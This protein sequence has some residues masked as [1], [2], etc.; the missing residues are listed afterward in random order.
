MVALG[1][2]NRDTAFAIGIALVLGMLFVPLPPA[3]LDL[4]LACSL[5][6]SVLILMVAL[7]IPKPL[8]FNSFPTLLLVVTMLRLSLNV[9]STRL[10]LSEG[11]TGTGAAGDVIEGFSRFI[12]GG[13]FV[14]GI[15]IFAIL[16]VI[17]FVVITKG[18]TRIAEVSA[19]FSLDAMPGKQ[20]AIDADLGSGLI[21]EA[22]AKARRK[23]LEDESGFFGAMDGASKFVRGDAVA[24]IIITLINVI[25]GIL[26]GVLQHGM[27]VGSAASNYTVLTIGDGLVTQIPA[28]VVSLAA[29]LIVTKGGTEGATNE[30]ILSQLGRFPKALFMAAGLLAFIGLLPGFPTAIFLLLSAGLVGLGV[31]LR[32][33]AAETADRE[34]RESAAAERSAT[35]EEE[36]SVQEKMRLDDLRLDLGSG[37]V[38]LISRSD[39]ALPGK[40][41]SLRNLFAQD[42]GFVLPAVRIK[43]E[44]SLP[45]NTYAIL[46][47]GVEAARGE[48]R[49][50]GMMVINPAGNDIDLAGE[51]TREP[52]FGLDAVWI[53]PG[54]VGEAE[55]RGYTVVDPESVATTHLTE[56]IKEHMPELL[57]Y[58]AVQQLVEGLERSYQK[59]VAEIS[60]P[61]PQILLQHVLQSLLTERV[62]IRNLP[63]IVEAVAE[64]T[65]STS[66]V[67]MVTEHVRQKLANQ[68]CRGLMD[69]KGFVPVITLSATWERE[70]SEAVRVNGDQRNFLMSPQRVQEFVLAARREI[71]TFAQR[72][73][74]PALMVGP[75]VRSNVRGML[76]RVSPMTPVISHAE[77]HRK[78]SLRTVATIE[79]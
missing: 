65:R 26:I 52:T 28:L 19:R 40:I 58:G 53:D 4:A 2:N 71:Q 21:D 35:A 56:V 46:V 78:A 44:P 5:S 66:N 79:T 70:F 23:E 29:G 9:S 34:K 32:R 24:G 63:L 55:Q 1:L 12:V 76:E 13:D 30:A 16:V 14:I 73:E 67:T 74:W 20:M 36:D 48:L 60:A 54:L 39:A 7:W 41:K 47:Q 33:H 18:S 64:I 25:G 57:T 8:D 49:P 38:P 43:D 17:N 61:T 77:V 42:Y 51:K 27:S 72:D 50:N 10:I 15:V 3:V 22:Q 45:T 31:V 68:I 6:V 69:D 75:E 59:L 11:H 62:S 37:L